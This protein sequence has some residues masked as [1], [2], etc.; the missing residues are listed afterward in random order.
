MRARVTRFLAVPAVALALTGAAG[1]CA[2]ASTPRPPQGYV[3]DSGS[4][5][6][7][8]FDASHNSTLDKPGPAIPITGSPG[9][10]VAAPNYQFVYAAS[11]DGVTPIGTDFDAP[12]KLI[13]VPGGV[14]GMVIT[15]DGKTL[16]VTTD[17]TSATVNTI[18]PVN[19]LTHRAERPITF[20]PGPGSHPS[21]LVITPDGKTV[22]TASALG[23]VTPISTIT[24]R[25]C[26]PI[27]FGPKDPDGTAHLAISPDGKTLYAFVSDPG[28]TLT[29]VTPISTA[30]DKA[31]KPVPV[32]QGPQAIVFAPDGK[33]AYV[34]STGEGPK[35][36]V[37]AKLTPINTATNTAD[38][39]INLGPPATDLSMAIMPNGE[40]LYVSA[41]WHGSHDNTVFSVSTATNT[42]LK[43]YW[44]FYPRAL[45]LTPDGTIAFIMDGP[46]GGT[47]TVESITT[48]NNQYHVGFGVGITSVAMTIVP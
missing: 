11:T 24:N 47:G 29:T 7:T 4:H 31:G 5:D 27:P 19:T 2:S 13:A 23:T 21:A 1:V 12:G 18:I 22:Y 14:A 9:V 20:A 42:I 35:A 41:I 45:A 25:P 33:T 10:L 15:P 37:R 44:P 32:G 38:R 6:V 40:K 46:P 17:T 26:R 36:F 34:A 28:R 16:Y 3:A 48:A 39:F 8:P 43:D 30:T